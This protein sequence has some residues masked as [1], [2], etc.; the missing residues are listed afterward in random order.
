[1]SCKASEVANEV[2]EAVV[3]DIQS[4]LKEG[5]CP[6]MFGMR[7]ND[8]KKVAFIIATVHYVSEKW[9]L[10]GLVLFTSNFLTGEEVIQGS[11]KLRIDENILGNV[12]Q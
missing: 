10:R 5:C 6:I 12:V 11:A 3:P 4:A 7:T 8:Y 1:M 2:Q 9:K